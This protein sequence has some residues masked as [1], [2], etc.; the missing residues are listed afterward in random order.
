VYN[1][2]LHLFTEADL[3]RIQRAVIQSHP[4]D[5]DWLID[6]MKK[7]TIALLG[8][9]LATVNLDDLAPIVF[10]LLYVI[11]N[12]LVNFLRQYLSVDDFRALYMSFLDSQRQ[13][14]L[15]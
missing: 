9:I 3:A 7:V 10:D 5:P 14:A 8:E 12:E 15:V 2:P 13:D 6:L 4:D 1:R 11:T